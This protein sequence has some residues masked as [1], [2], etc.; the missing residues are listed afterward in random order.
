V[1][2][3]K[4]LRAFTEVPVNHI[5]RSTLIIAVFFGLD[6]VLGF[7]RQALI[8]RQFGLSYE[9]DVFNA[10]NNI[11]DLLSALISGGALGVA[12][13]PVLSEHM[14]KR[15]RPEAW[16]VFTRIVNLAFLATAGFSLLIALLAGPLVRHLVAPGFPAEQ[17]SLTI[18][19]M[20]LDLLAILIFSISGLVMAG[21]QANQHF[22][23]PAMAPG[24]YN[25]GQIFGVAVLAPEEGLSF[26]GFNL[27]GFG[28]GIHGLVY[29]VI[30]GALL[31]L[32]VQTP[33]LAHFQFRWEPRLQLDHPG[34]RQ[35]L[36]LLGPRILTMFFLQ[37]FFIARDNLASRLGEGAVTALNMG[38]F[39]MQV[40]ETLIGTALA[41]AVLPT[42]A[43]L[44][45][46][47]DY[48]SFSATIRGAMQSLVGITL[49]IA[50]VLSVALPPLVE[51]GFGYDAAATERVVWA[52]RAYL[53][54]LMGHSLLELAA[55]SFYAH[56]DARTPLYL[57]ALNVLV[58]LILAIGL[59]QTLGANGIALANSIA[60]TSEAVL[61]LYL[62]R[63]RFQGIGLAGVTALRALSAAGLGSAVA[64]MLLEWLPL[65]PLISGAAALAGGGLAAL[66]LIWPALIGL[67]RL[68]RQ[69]GAQD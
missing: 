61:L 48:H 54:G 31:H 45:S 6:K 46:Q 66:P 42:L 17:Q 20:R 19:L 62:L 37:V 29:G 52:T 24:L 68:G 40:P 16:A 33:G 21:L 69:T 10:A 64:Y 28:L 47:G 43:E 13:I 30:L 14:Q 53:L 60:F 7:M 50:A 9:I 34:V 15:G 18:E 44:Y 25:I 23:L 22:L 59:S 38:W 58:Y 11:P 8:A 12:L 5:A 32:L 2:R 36:R 57:A 41:I 39:I 65:H 26:G 63:R 35:V 3:R 51:Y 67:L 27:P 56:Q 55:R 4:S 49:P 1:L